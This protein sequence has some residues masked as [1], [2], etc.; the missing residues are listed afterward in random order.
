MALG[1]Q[2][3]SWTYKVTSTRYSPGP[4]KATTLHLDMGGP[5]S[6]DLA[7]AGQGTLTA[8]A[9]LGAKSGT[10]SWCGAVYLND[11]GITGTIGQGTSEEIGKHKWRLVGVAQTAEGRTM[12]VEAEGD[13]ATQTLAGKLIEWK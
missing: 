12:G 1:K 5:I 9:E 2:I 11:G 8:V 6:G 4:G 13:F 10:W 7:G 3:A